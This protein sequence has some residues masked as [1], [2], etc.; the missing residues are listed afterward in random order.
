M[1]LEPGTTLGPYEVTAKI[2]EGGMGVVY[3]ARD[4]KLDRDVALKVLPQAFTDNPDRLARFEREAKVLASLNHPNIGH[5]Y[6]L[7][8]SGDTRALVLELVEGPTLAD[9]VAQGPI[10]IEEALPIAKQIAEALEAAHEAGVIHR[11]LKPANVK[12]RE[13]GTVKVLDFGLA[14]AFQPDSQ[15]RDRSQSPTVTATVG[16]TREGV[17]LG[18][19][20]YM[21]PEQARGRTLDRRTDVWS[22]ACVVYEMLS[23]RQAF[24]ADTT[25]D[26]LAAV[27][28]REPDWRA[29]PS[30]TPLRIVELIRR[31]LRKEHAR[32]LRDLGDAAIEIEEARGGTT[33]AETD[34]QLAPSSK[35][36][37]S[38][39][40]MAV[41]GLAVGVALWAVVGVSPAPPPAVS[42]LVVTLAPDQ[43]I[44]LTG[45]AY[46]LAVS[47]GGERLAY[48]ASSGGQ[49]RLLLRELDE[50]AAR[51][52]PGTEGAEYPFFSPDGQ[53]IGFFAEATLHKVAV[54]GGRPLEI[55]EALPRRGASWGPDGHIYFSGRPGLYRVPADGGVAEP[56]TSD[57][58]TVDQQVHVWPHVLPD[59]RGL[60]STVRTRDG[61]SDEAYSLAVLS[62][63]TGEWRVLRQGNQG[64]FVDGGYLAYHAS[65]G[66]IH[67][68]PFDLDRQQLT[69]PPASV[70]AGAYRA[71]SSGAAYF[72]VSRT[73]TLVYVPGGFDRALVRVD[74]TGRDTPLTAETRGFRFPKIS[75]D[76]R[77][78]AVTIDPRP[79]EV[80]VLDV[81]RALTKVAD[82]GH[83]LM[84]Q[85]TPD[86]RQFVFSSSRSGNHDLY[87]RS[88]DGT[89]DAQ[90]LLER[91]SSQYASSWSPD[92]QVLT[93]HEQVPTTGW[94][95]WALQRGGEPFPVLMT[96]ADEYGG[97]VSPDGNWLAYQSSETGFL[98]VYVQSFPGADVR[99]RISID[100]GVDPV[101]SRDGTELFFS[102]D[103]QL[104]AV[105]IET[106]TSL[107][108]GTPRIL[109][110]WPHDLSQRFDVF[111]D[112]QS[113]VMIKTD[114]ES[115][116]TRF[117]V[118]LNW[119]QELLERVPTGQQ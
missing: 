37:L 52:I 64:Q 65:N 14:K 68:A 107:D 94:D 86:G 93:F 99:Q 102:N 73:G 112:S 114:P 40:L 83:N 82:Q 100:G 60:V 16:G 21:S 116:P 30:S 47:P 36:W 55:T 34:Q 70:L 63:A 6:G 119:D 51:V 109:F 92:G 56:V 50:L 95:I 61:F 27:L 43:E 69:G 101:W 97:A 13:D 39:G 29:L 32:R 87:L 41:T 49:R 24:G 42:R 8:E 4:T 20:A 1:P 72:A 111:P 84:P 23:G 9:R 59:G 18:T 7:E 25:S 74:R 15:G 79:S 113:F 78:V 90:L 115:T 71:R 54:A 35:P 17:I 62:F 91:P 22:F 76:G 104:L 45:G 110:P 118:V 10:P 5:I 58:P 48:V 96:S 26:A 81:A 67:V 2:G 106:E 19:A 31:C 88:F 103:G 46:P 105:P 3:R 38:A 44:V 108:V 75:P 12:V 28:G 89:G 33:A 77:L 66:E 98:E 57:D 53:W 80:W 85:W 117:N 11:D